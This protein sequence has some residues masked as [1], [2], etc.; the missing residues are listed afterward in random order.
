MADPLIRISG[1]DVSIDDG[2]TRI[3][4]D[5]HLEIEEGEVLCLVG[6]SGSGKT[7]LALTLL[8]YCRSGAE[9]TAGEVVVDGMSL[10]ALSPR[11]IRALRGRKLAYVPQDPGTALNPA[12]SIREQLTEHLDRGIDQDATISEVLRDVG[13]PADP[14]FLKRRPGELSGGQQQRIAIAIAVVGGPEVLVLDE[15]TT[16]LDVQSQAM[17]LDLVNRICKAR[18]LT[19][20]YVTHDM[21]VVAEVASRVVVMYDGT[22]VEDGP[23]DQVL[24][25]PSHEYTRTLLDA[26]PDVNRPRRPGAE[27]LTVSDAADTGQD[28]SEA[29]QPILETVGINASYGDKQVLFDLSLAVQRRGCT[30]LVGESGSGKSTLSRLLIGLHRQSYEG[31]VL[32]EGE[33]LAQ[34]ARRR[35]TEQRRHLQYIFQNPYASLN[36]RATVENSLLRARRHFTGESR[37]AASR[38]IEAQAERVGLT[39]QLLR[40]YPSELSGGQRQRVAIARGLLAEPTMLICDEITSALDVSVQAAIL[41]LLRELID[42]GLSMLFVT[43]DL[44]VV[45]SLADDVVVMQYGRVV[46][47]GPTERVFTEPESE[48]TRLLIDLAPSLYAA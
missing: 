40:R 21:G 8:G 2:D 23:R 16:G 34:Q 15:P 48:Y 30:A 18:S 26:V 38:E 41:D 35:P 10:F 32:L 28:S 17:V 6:E 3:V 1:L 42:Q 7:T 20:V 46:E 36:P 39:R 27:A 12:M 19:A 31:R 13:L 37:R 5:I 14:Q 9:V 43:H 45:R 33:E 47:H 29:L 4:R 24:Y 25:S 44:G 22:I 11:E